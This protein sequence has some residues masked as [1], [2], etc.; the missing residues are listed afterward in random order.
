MVEGVICV[1][2]EQIKANKKRK[3]TKRLIFRTVI[4]GVMVAAVIFALISNFKKDSTIYKVGDKAPD[5]QLQQVNKNN[6]LE[7][8]QLSDLEGKGVMLNFWATYCKPCEAE[9]PFM[10]K[11]YPDYK[12]KG[13]EIVAVSLDANELVIN[14]FIDKY[15]LTFPTPHDK[16]SEVMDLY[17]VGPIPSTF[18]IN[19]DGEIEEIVEG[20]LTLERLEG[21]FKQ[22]Q[23]K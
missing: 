12:D 20:A 11:L 6:E 22:I 21:Y 3:K 14:R 23:P 4:L 17:K 8:V 15:D 5:F 18:F 10:E 2:L 7:T 16:E 1:S 13:I 19:P 9:M